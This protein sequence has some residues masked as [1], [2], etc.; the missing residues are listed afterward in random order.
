MTDLVDAPAAPVASTEAA[1]DAASAPSVGAASP[2]WPIPSSLSP[3]RVS[4]F[5]SC[6]MQFRFSSVQRLPEPPGVA[7]TRGTVVHRAL[8]LLF[9]LPRHERTPSAL[10]RCLTLAM[11]EHEHH[12]DYVGLLLDD[13]GRAEF[14]AGCRALIERYFDMEDPT[15]VRDIGLEVRMAADV[16]SLQLRG[17]IDRLELDDDGELVVTDYKTG[18]APSGRYE[19][20]SL[21]G[22]H[23]YSFLCE[24]VLGRRPARIRLMYLASGETIETVPSA[25]SVRFITTRTAAVWKAVERACTTGDFRPNTSRL[26]DWCSFRAWCPA[27]DGDPD[28]AAAEAAAAYAELVGA[29]ADAAVRS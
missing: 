2:A 26:C 27:F 7:T 29:G 13:V 6:P 23:F 4:S 28:L 17:I 12:P 15:T 16:G 9:V 24:A 1:A 10:D 3:S 20:K 22:V 5:T 8:E 18:R 14:D 19:Q 21:A 11:Q 25:Q